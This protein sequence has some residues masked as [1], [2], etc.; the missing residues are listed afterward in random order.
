MTSIVALKARQGELIAEITALRSKITSNREQ[1]TRA[2][3]TL[4]FAKTPEQT[5]A[6]RGVIRGLES[7]IAEDSANELKL[8][9]ELGDISQ[10]IAA[11]QLKQG[12]VDS[13]GQV[14]ANDDNNKVV[15]PAETPVSDANK[16]PSN[17]SK[18]KENTDSGTNPPQIKEAPSIQSVPSSL[19]EP[20]PINRNQTPQPTAPGSPGPASPSENPN[21][22]R[23]RLEE[24]FKATGETPN[25]DPLDNI[26]D[27]YSSYTYNISIY[28]IDEEDLLKFTG[29]KKKQLPQSQ[30]LISSGGRPIN[31]PDLNEMETM[32][33]VDTVDGR[34]QSFPLDF[35]IEDVRLQHQV[36]GKANGLAHATFQ[37]Q[38]KIFEPNGVTF[39]NNLLAAT[40]KYLIKKGKQ[41]TQNYAAQPYLM[42][43]KFYGYDESGNLLT[44]GK[45]KNVSDGSDSTA[46][47]EKYIPFMF[48]E[49]KFKISK[50]I[51]EYQCAG[52][53]LMPNL[54]AQAIHCTVNSAIQLN[55]VTVKD[56]LSGNEV[57]PVAVDDREYQSPAA[58]ANAN[59]MS[60]AV[61]AAQAASNTAPPKAN[62]A[63]VPKTVNGLTAY[64]NREQEDLVK[65]GTFEHPNIYEIVFTDS[66][67]SD[68]KIKPPGQTD[69]AKTPMNQSNV[70]NQVLNPKAQSIEMNNKG[71]AAH[72]GQSI[73]QLIE[74]TIRNS[75]Y[76]YEQQNEIIDPKTQKPIEKTPPGN[77]MGWYRI[78]TQAIPLE[79]DHKRKDYAYKITYQ[80]SPYRISSTLSDY[81]PSSKY[82]GVHKR[83]QY[84]FSG[85]NT[86]I[87][88]FN[89][90]FN[91]LYYLVVSKKTGAETETITGNYRKTLPDAKRAY[92][93]NSNQPNMGSDGNTNEGAANAADYLYSPADQSKIKLQVVGDPAW[94]WQGEVW[95]GVAKQDMNYDP[96]LPDGTINFDAGETWFEILFNKP[97]DYNLNTGLMDPTT[98]NYRPTNSNSSYPEQTFIYKPIS[99]TSTFSKGAFT[100]ELVGT[101]VIWQLPIEDL[102]KSKDETQKPAKQ[103]TK[104]KAFPADVSDVR[105][106]DNAIA[107]GVYGKRYLLT[108]ARIKATAPSI[109]APGIEQIRSS[110]EYKEATAAGVTPMSAEQFAKNAFARNEGGSPVTSGGQPIATSQTDPAPPIN[111]NNNPNSGAPQTMARDS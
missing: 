63:K 56:V 103:P 60:P 9:N 48:S 67:I 5:T 109:P 59:L 85:K 39:L 7:Q 34:S 23:A 44:A 84:L 49:I 47:I 30:L 72:A 27:L 53:G 21:P 36:P 54:A 68:A 73:L 12:N 24:I 40:E 89:Q 104:L 4:Q 42:T 35:Y 25:I 51:V 26:L 91:Y 97:V 33:N 50:N 14:V 70:P 8:T 32:A 65:R 38:F 58:T 45:R 106:I 94:I 28:I 111:S 108:P 1:L 80:V 3:S 83:Y 98:N 81:F 110:P 2:K 82:M 16:L 19:P 71:V 76:I 43:I 87:I 100:Q 41:L 29:S 99:I 74:F 18:F 102:N 105:R 17:A 37:L 86:S 46:I 62:A 15:S 96:F 55:G 93:P 52:V 107:S 22:V 57:L 69:L 61:A 90:D 79:Y 6:I 78:G 11:A 31:N 10:Q 101:I 77:V 64:L 95:Q 66:I 88:D 13:A 20:G 75:T 92:Q